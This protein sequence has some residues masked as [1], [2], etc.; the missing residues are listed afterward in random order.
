MFQR[1][2]SNAPT[3]SGLSEE[4]RLLRLIF[5]LCGVSAPVVNQVMPSVSKTRYLANKCE[6]EIDKSYWSMIEEKEEQSQEF[7]RKLYKAHETLK[8]LNLSSHLTDNEGIRALI[9]EKESRLMKNKQ[10]LLAM[11]QNRTAISKVLIVC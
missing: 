10:E 5:S 2:G 8:N 3:V 4:G 7:K 9:S 1:L 6:A 11:Q